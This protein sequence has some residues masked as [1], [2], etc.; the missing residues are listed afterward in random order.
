MLDESAFRAPTFDP[1]SRPVRCGGGRPWYFPRPAMD[2][3]PVGSSRGG[4]PAPRT[5]LGR[6]F[7]EA[8]DR[9]MGGESTDMEGM[10]H[11]GRVMLSRNYRIPDNAWGLIL[12][13]DPWSESDHETW[14]EVMDIATGQ[15]PKTIDCY[16]RAAMALAGGYHERFIYI[17]EMHAII[18]LAITQRRVPAADRWVLSLIEERQSDHLM[19]LAIC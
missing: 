7:D 14:K 16:R 8:L 15:S 4:G 5:T 12:R 19:S 13:Y 11:L 3:N 6:E 17:D 18:E 9:A 10:F 2:L 1:N